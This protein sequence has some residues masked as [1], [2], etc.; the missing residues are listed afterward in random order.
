MKAGK[1]TLP[2][3]SKN[4]AKQPA[5]KPLV[6]KQPKGIPMLLG[7]DGLYKGFE[8]DLDRKLLFG[9]DEERCNILYPE[10]AN[11]IS[12]IQFEI[13]INRDNG[14]VYVID[15]YSTYGTNVNGHRLETNKATFLNNGD[16]VMFGEGN[17]F[18]VTY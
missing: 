3:I 14:Q 10:N 8:F 16:I 1:F 18:K 17:V 2:Q 15:Q 12:K 11:G 6:M 13:G 7:I 9:R 5:V 4:T